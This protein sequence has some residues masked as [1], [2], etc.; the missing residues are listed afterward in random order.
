MGCSQMTNSAGLVRVVCASTGGGG[1]YETGSAWLAH[2]VL[3]LEQ[4]RLRVGFVE[5]PH[6]TGFP[7]VTVIYASGFAVPAGAP[8]RRLSVEL[9]AMLADS[10]TQ[11]LR[12]AAGLELPSLP[13]AAAALAARDTLGW[14]AEFLRASA[15]A[16]APWGAR[17]AEWREVEA[18]LPDL[19]DQITIGH[20]DPAVAAH[21]MARRLDRLLALSRP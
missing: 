4:H 3:Y 12:A 15:H 2:S 20:V 17:I 14:E 21:D 8:H 7:P 19:M 11:S 16:R 18:L 10:V 5:I 1:R 6:R 13:G 9:A